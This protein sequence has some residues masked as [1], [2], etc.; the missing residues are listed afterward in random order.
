MGLQLRFEDVEKSLEEVKFLVIDVETTGASAGAGEITEIGAVVV[1]GGQV[2][3]SYQSLLAIDGYLPAAISELTGIYPE[4]LQGAPSIQRA[5]LR[6]LE[7]ADGA[8]IVGH[9]VRFDLA[10]VNAAIARFAPVLLLDNESLDTLGLAR[11]LLIGEVRDFKLGTLANQLRLDHQPEH[12]A[13]ADVL[14][15][16]DLLHYLIERASSYGATT[17]RE[18]RSLPN[19]IARR[20]SSKLK[21]CNY[22]PRQTGVYWTLNALGEVT[23]V[24]KARDLNARFRS[25]F[26][27]DTRRKVDP[28]LGAIDT[29]CYMTFDSELES[30]VAESRL[31]QRLQ[32]CF[33]SI[34]KRRATDYRYISLQGDSCAPSTRIL[35]ASVPAEAAQVIGPFR[36]RKSAMLAENAL[37]SALLFAPSGFWH[38]N[39]EPICA[40][41]RDGGATQEFPRALKAADL[42]RY[43]WTKLAILSDSQLYEQ[44][45]KLR[46]GSNYLM[47]AMVRQYATMAIGALEHL[48]ITS[49]CTAGRLIL[50]RGVMQLRIRDA[51]AISL[52]GTKASAVKDASLA[53]CVDPPRRLNIQRA[54]VL[55]ELATFEETWIVWKHLTTNS[56][57]LIS[58]PRASIH[59]PIS[60]GHRSF[61]PKRASLKG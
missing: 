56:E 17:V 40:E 55:P 16:V 10:F 41:G 28:L 61:L 6:L 53:A 36:S 39:R 1:K 46:V 32:P 45:E 54:E 23:Y 42:S 7:M 58:D 15:T 50:H 22:L 59:M 37:R 34:G 26:T 44:A 52:S 20:H 31:I 3:D 38:M 27:S 18:L 12:R 14:A 35:K 13:M 43:L 47:L 60:L 51:G 5:M 24:G 19:K 49:T 33:N 4:M 11:K 48:E 29:L 21:A 8:V 9:N 2:L 30:L 25:Y 57:F